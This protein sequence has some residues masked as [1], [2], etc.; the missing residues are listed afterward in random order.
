MDTLYAIA[1]ALNVQVEQ[2]L[3]TEPKNRLISKKGV[4][5]AEY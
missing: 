4:P 3:H 5:S 2:L 1:I